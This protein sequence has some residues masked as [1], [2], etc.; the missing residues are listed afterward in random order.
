MALIGVVF[1]YYTGIRQTLF[2][3]VRLRGSW[4]DSGRYSHDWNT[5]QMEPFIA[6]DGCPAWQAMVGLD[7]SRCGWWFRWGLLGNAGERQDQ[8]L[9]SVENGDGHLQREFILYPENQPQC[10]WLS[11]A[12]RLGANKL[13]LEGRSLA[14]I[15]FAVW[16]PN[17]QSVETV[18]GE[19]ASGYIWSAD[20]RGKQQSFFMTKREDNIWRT[21]STEPALALFSNWDHKLYMFR[22]TRNDGSVAYRTDLYSRCQ[23]GSGKIDPESEVGLSWDGLR[24][25]LDGT[26]SCSVVI[27]PEQVTAEYA[28]GVWPE[29]K[30]VSEAEF[31]KGEFD[32]TKPLPVR[33]EDLIVYELHVGALGVNHAGPGTLEDAIALLPHLAELGINAVELLPMSEYEGWASWG[34]GTSHYFAIEFVSGGRDQFKYFVRACHRQGIAVILDVV[35]NHFTHDGERAEWMYDSPWH[36]RN[37]YYWYEG[38]PFDYPN[39]NPPGHGGY[40]DNGSTG[41]TPNFREETV[42]RMFTSSAIVLITEFHVDCFRVDLTQAIHSDQKLHADGRSVE[43]ARIM[44]GRFL[45]EWVRTLRLLRPQVMLFAED[46]TGRADMVQSLEQGGIGFDAVWYAEWYHH[47]IGDS[48]NDRNKARLLHMAGSSSNE[49]PLAMDYLAGSLPATSRKVIYHESHDEAGNSQYCEGGQICYSARTMMVAANGNPGRWRSVAEA[50]TRVVTG[51]TMLT[52]GIPMFLMAEEVG[53]TKP[54]RYNDFLDNRENI[55]DLKAGDGAAMFRFYRDLIALRR[56]F[57]AL[58]LS[59]VEV[60]HAHNSNRIL[61]FRR[62]WDGEEFLVVASLNNLAFSNGYILSHL[63]LRDGAWSEVLNSDSGTYGGQGTC[64]HGSVKSE[65]GTLSLRL[66]SN[67]IIV[68]R[69]F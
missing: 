54:Y 20:G 37:I 57:E 22:I 64:N 17:A 18:I 58:R 31:W 47:L 45:R 10:Y 9:I 24:Q 4:D 28:E 11:H 35:Y 16:A 65:Y 21:E 5:V 62:W 29:T 26:K 49:M 59:N 53:A 7:D 2:N 41:Y 12:R 43:M 34:Y 23:I 1:K 13:W 25:T 61:V 56:S 60:L 15:Q 46:H 39:D 32:H 27:D 42:R 55:P 3:N 68:F 19:P 14:A 33:I 38:T 69:C 6:E 50:R 66:P 63:S 36:D 52:P 8:W 67:A 51:L 40:L 44:G 30:W 48:T